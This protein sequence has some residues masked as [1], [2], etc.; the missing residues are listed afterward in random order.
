MTVAPQDIAAGRFKLIRQAQQ[1]LAK[2]EA[3]FAKSVARREELRR[4]IGPAER[5]DREALGQA[6]VDR[7]PEPA[8]ESE[9]LEAELEREERRAD[10]FRAH[11]R[12]AP[13]R[14]RSDRCV[15]PRTVTA[16]RPVVGR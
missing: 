16:P 10:E 5:R 8:G 13:R 3:I 12:G 11:A 4:E 9:K 6:I 2:A 7:K 1:G 15:P 14:C